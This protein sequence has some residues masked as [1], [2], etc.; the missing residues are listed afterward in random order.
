MHNKSNSHVYMQYT[1]AVHTHT[2]F[3]CITKATAMFTCRI[4]WLCTHTQSKKYSILVNKCGIQCTHHVYMRPVFTCVYTAPVYSKKILYAYQYLPKC[5]RHVY[6]IPHV[7]SV[8]HCA[9][10]KYTPTQ[11][12]IHSKTLPEC[13]HT[14]YIRSY[15][16]I[17]MC[18]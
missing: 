6:N 2:H 7:V 18:T 16:K 1:L 9:I 13:I 8:Q 14:V 3:V 4:H 15:K 17:F 10:I 11:G 5:T 12:C